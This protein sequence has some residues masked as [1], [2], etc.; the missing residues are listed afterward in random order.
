MKRNYSNAAEHYFLWLLEHAPREVATEALLQVGVANYRYDEH[1]LI[2]AVNGIRLLDAVGWSLAP[3]VLRSIVRYNFM[4]SIWADAPAAG[5][6]EALLERYGLLQGVAQ[7]GKNEEGEVEA[8]RGE[9]LAHSLEDLPEVIARALA[10]GLSLRGA[11][12]A[13][14]LAAS[15][16]FLQSASANSMG[17]HFMTGANALRWVCGAFPSLGARGLLLWALGPE[18]RGV[19][20][21]V[22]PVEEMTPVSA[23]LEAISEAISENDPV[24]TAACTQAYC[25]AEGDVPALLQRLGEWA[26]KDSATEM[27]GMKHH[28]AMVEE[29]S[30]TH[31]SSA[32]VHLAAQAKEAALHAGKGTAV[33]ERAAEAL[34]R[35]GR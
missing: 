12:E 28:Q 10:G 32:W 4:P 21:S 29:F 6:V 31:A 25:R 16:L 14:S 1:K 3:V 11:G 20:G 15:A 7:E 13:I 18:T 35:S 34:R 24:R 33:Y 26:A 8:L 22:A 5:E 19:K 23:S 30:N 17:I 2:A 27:H 9:L